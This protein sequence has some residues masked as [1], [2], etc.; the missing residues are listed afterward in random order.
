MESKLVGGDGDKYF[1]ASNR[2][3][4]V[5]GDASDHTLYGGLGPETFH[6]KLGE[7]GSDTVEDFT[8]GEDKF[9]VSR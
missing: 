9:M 1:A 6:F 5:K 3:D 7:S 4:A 2:Q 8:N